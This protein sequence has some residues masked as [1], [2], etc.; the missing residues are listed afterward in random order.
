VGIPALLASS[1]LSLESVNSAQRRERRLPGV[2]RVSESQ[3]L[4]IP[5][6]SASSPDASIG[7]SHVNLVAG[8]TGSPSRACPCCTTPTVA[9]ASPHIQWDQ[10]GLQELQRPL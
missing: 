7:V 6:I 8:R 2:L 1:F 10:H 3:L 9:S 5:A 4:G